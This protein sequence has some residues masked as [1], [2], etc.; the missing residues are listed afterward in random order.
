LCYSDVAT[1][2]SRYPGKLKKK[3]SLQQDYGSCDL[4]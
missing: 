1:N 3:G 4:H 2:F